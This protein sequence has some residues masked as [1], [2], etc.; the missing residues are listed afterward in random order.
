MRRSPACSQAQLV[1]PALTASLAFWLF[2]LLAA[3]EQCRAAGE[4]STRSGAAGLPLQHRVA[5]KRAGGGRAPLYGF[6]LGKRSPLLVLG[7]AGE[8][9]DPSA[10][11]VEDEEDDAMAAERTSRYFQEKRGP[12]DSMRYG[13]GLGKRWG[14]GGEYA[15]LGAEKYDRP[16][17][18]YAM[19]KRG[20]KDN[21][22]DFMK[23]RYNFGLGRR[24][25]DGDADAGERWKRSL[26]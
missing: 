3:T 16:R 11:D 2:L 21:F 9:A 12:R 17:I 22:D 20:K 24:S 25:I 6:G 15:S 1:R 18:S 14:L 19:N 5:D 4:A 10:L 23:R 13:F 26:N 7:G 8:E